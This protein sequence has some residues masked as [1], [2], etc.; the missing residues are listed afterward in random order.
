MGLLMKL[1]FTRTPRLATKFGFFVFFVMITAFTLASTYFIANTSAQ[2]ETKRLISVYDRGEIS[3]F[4]TNQETI[5]A[6][7]RENGI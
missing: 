2:D 1:R 6:A 5:G 3:S 4:L 7:L